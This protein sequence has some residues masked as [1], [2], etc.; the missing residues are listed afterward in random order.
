MAIA[1]APKS[2][3][4]YIAPEPAV[5]DARF[6][7]VSE[8]GSTVSDGALSYDSASI[9]PNALRGLAAV[10]TPVRVRTVTELA[11]KV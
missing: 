7:P 11:G 3:D 8:Q 6:K 5:M 10:I 4:L 9:R 1:P 2:M